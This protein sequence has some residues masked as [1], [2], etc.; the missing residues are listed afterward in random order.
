MHSEVEGSCLLEKN[1]EK[2]PRLEQREHLRDKA[3]NYSGASG[4]HQLP[5]GWQGSLS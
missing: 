3:V 2:L 5:Q 4:L 1:G